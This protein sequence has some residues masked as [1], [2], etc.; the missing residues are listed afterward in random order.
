M[1]DS[2]GKKVQE[3]FTELVGARAEILRGDRFPAAI[4][5]TITAALSGPGSGEE[6]MLEADNIAFHLT[7]WHAEA[8]FLVALHL[9][10]ER[11]TSQEGL[12]SPNSCSCSRDRSGAVGGTLHAKHIP[13]GYRGQWSDELVI[14]PAGAQ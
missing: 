8:A 14:Q 6:E 3:I 2:V 13:R 10:P 9:F 5:S 1:A 11:F 12:R 4:A 7:D